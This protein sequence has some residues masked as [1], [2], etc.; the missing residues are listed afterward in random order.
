MFLPLALLATMCPDNDATY[1]IATYAH[2][3][4]KAHV[5]V[6]IT[7]PSQ[8]LMGTLQNLEAFSGIQTFPEGQWIVTCGTP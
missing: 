3:Y 6:L 4:A 1:T 8:M 5:M 2:K 7:R